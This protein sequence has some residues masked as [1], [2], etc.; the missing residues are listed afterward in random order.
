MGVTANG[1][2]ILFY[3]FH[4]GC[5]LIYDQFMIIFD[6]TMSVDNSFLEILF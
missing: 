5:T 3:T 4:I 6:V 2:S 1:L